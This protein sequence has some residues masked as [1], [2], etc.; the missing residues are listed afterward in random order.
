MPHF[1]LDE[2]NPGWVKAWVVLRDSPWHLYGA[3]PSRA[4]ADV[5]CA[6]LGSQYEVV[7][8]AHRLA[9]DDFIREEHED[10][11][12][13]PKNATRWVRGDQF[14]ELEGVIGDKG[15]ALVIN[16][17]V[18]WEK[19]PLELREQHPL[20]EHSRCMSMYKAARTWSAQAGFAA[21]GGA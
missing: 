13:T 18:P 11:A 2:S 4:E 7:Y 21:H 19:L 9:S 14:L 3:Y 17:N 8:G 1:P 15:P 12:A 10:V 5:Y 6:A 20:A 16:T